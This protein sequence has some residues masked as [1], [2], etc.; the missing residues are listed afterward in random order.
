MY[1]FFFNFEKNK[2]QIYEA[3]IKSNIS[4]LLSLSRHSPGDSLF[5]SNFLPGYLEPGAFTWRHSPSRTTCPFKTFA[6]EQ[7]QGRDK[8]PEMLTS[9][10]PL[11]LMWTGICGLCW[12]KLSCKVRAGQEGRPRFQLGGKKQSCPS[13]PAASF[14]FEH[15]V[16]RL[17][18]RKWPPGW[19]CI[20][21]GVTQT[22]RGHV[23]LL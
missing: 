20:S 16:L 12:D 10:S 5:Q 13:G 2:S 23:D 18:M 15:E 21:A 14:Q 9:E 17:L 4:L 22:G 6:R 8:V 19:H 11:P 1:F 7:L 3:R